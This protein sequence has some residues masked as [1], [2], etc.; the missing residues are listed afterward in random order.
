MKYLYIELEIQD[1]ERN[2][3]HRCLHTTKCKNI[4][5]AGEYYTAHFWGF[6]ERTFND[7]A[8]YAHAGE[9]A[10]EC[11]DVKELTK[12]EFDFLH[13]IFRGG[14]KPNIDIVEVK[15]SD[16]ITE[17]EIK[18]F[19]ES[20][21]QTHEEICAELDLNEE[22]GEEFINEE[23]FW[24]EKDELWYPKFSSLFTERE[25]KIADYLRE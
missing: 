17:Q 10:I 22:G 7:N 2:H 16:N 6:S 20:W 19:K 5:F 8:W 14:E 12:P 25:Q 15:N 18:K 23:N 13:Y 21:G 9:I 24:H 11:V 1:G 4:N 3:T